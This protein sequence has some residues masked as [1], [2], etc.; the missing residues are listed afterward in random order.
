MSTSGLSGMDD[1]WEAGWKER[2]RISGGAHS[3]LPVNIGTCD[4]WRI[5]TWG[6]VTWTIRA[7]AAIG[8]WFCPVLKSHAAVE[9]GQARRG[10]TSLD[11]SMERRRFAPPICGG[12]EGGRLGECCPQRVPCARFARFFCVHTPW[13][14]GIYIT[15]AH[16]PSSLISTTLLTYIHPAVA[17]AAQYTYIIAHQSCWRHIAVVLINQFCRCCLFC[18]FCL[19]VCLCLAEPG[20][21]LAAL[22]SM[23]AQ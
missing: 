16:K 17:E 21:K 18:L 10:E 19:S 2:K 9:K 20:T 7:R 6:S 22:H 12:R 5:A 14:V 3:S 1:R 15:P 8:F 13:I 11:R 4:L 23:A